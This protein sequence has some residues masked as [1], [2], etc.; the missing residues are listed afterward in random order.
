MSEKGTT[1]QL[2]KI[3]TE[4]LVWKL[5]KFMCE[6]NSIHIIRSVYSVLYTISMLQLKRITNRINFPPRTHIFDVCIPM[7]EIHTMQIHVEKKM[8]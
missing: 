3:I 6:L 1:I 5:A 8:P 7:E 4:H 2:E